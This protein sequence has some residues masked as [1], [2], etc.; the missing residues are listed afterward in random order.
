[1][2]KMDKKLM[3]YTDGGSR[4]NPGKAGCGVYIT[5]DQGTPLKKGYRFL[6]EA[7]NNVAEY[8]A[9]K[10]GIEKCIEMGAT[11]I[12]LHADSKLAIEQLSGNYKIKNAGLKEIFDE[13]QN[14]LSNWKGRISYT[15][16]PREENTEA[17]RLSNVAMDRGSGK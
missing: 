1:M 4:G 11:E 9:M 2:Q 6:G 17:D 16:I 3:L 13:I 7:T 14:I 5:D 12:C 10:I 8:T 15:H